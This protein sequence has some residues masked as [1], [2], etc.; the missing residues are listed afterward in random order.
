MSTTT[1]HTTHTTRGAPTTV[2]GLVTAIATVIP[3]GM[4]PAQA[5]TLAAPYATETIGEDGL[6]GTYQERLDAWNSSDETDRAIAMDVMRDNAVAPVTAEATQ[7]PTP[8]PAPDPDLPLPNVAGAQA[9]S[10]TSRASGRDQ[11]GMF[12][13]ID[14]RPPVL[15]FGAE[16]EDADGD[17]LPDGFENQLIQ[18]FMP[19]HHV[20]AGERSDAGMPRFVDQ[21]ALQAIGVGR[22]V[23]PLVHTRAAGLGGRW[24][25]GGGNQRWLM[26]EVEPPEL[27]PPPPPPPCE[28]P[29]YCG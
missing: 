10:A 26:T 20:S 4:T 6:P 22:Q 7:N 13:I 12:T 27:P 5:S 16:A 8:T 19:E 9:G 25:G 3:M 28:W 15:G 14:I 23:P 2:I 29:Y 11:I 17:A 18:S 1:T 24:E 21:S